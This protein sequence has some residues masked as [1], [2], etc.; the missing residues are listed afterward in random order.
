MNLSTNHRRR[1]GA[2]TLIELL[3]VIAIIAILAGMLL[4]ALAN[5]K[6]KAHGINCVNNMKQIQT[7]HMLYSGDFD[8]KMVSNDNDPR[9]A[10]AA[11]TN[12]WIQGNVNQYTAQY[13]S[14]ISEGLLFKYHS[15]TK[16]YVCPASRAKAATSTVAAAPAGTVAHHRTYS[17]SVGIACTV[18]ATSARRYGDILKSSDV[19]VFLEENP[20][21][22]D[23]GAQGIRSMTDLNNGQWSA[24]NP[25]S[26][27]HNN[28]AALSFTDGHAEIYKW[29]G[30]IAR[31]NN[32]YNDNTLRQYRTSATVNPLNGLTIARNDPDSIKLARG[33]NY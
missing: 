10:T 7:A 1:A 3:V 29:T 11:A 15:S 19:I 28:G 23:N 21:S 13:S 27:R 14:N 20:V 5:A 18:V 9:Q 8:D 16:S 32:I 26:G 4:P 33:L 6:G 2:F 25:P 30:E 24:W 12:A 17:M 31:L 22:I